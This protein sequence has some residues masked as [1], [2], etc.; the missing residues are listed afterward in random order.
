MEHVAMSRLLGAG[1]QQN[2][3]A[4]REW[5]ERLSELGNPRG[6]FGLGFLSSTG[7]GVNSSQARSL[8]YFTFAA[9]GGDHLAQMAMVSA[10]F[11]FLKL[12]CVSNFLSSFIRATACGLA[13][14]C[15]PIVS[16]RCLTTVA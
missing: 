12:S 1:V 16:Q 15:W 4:A 2:V 5:F 9:L 7:L 14:E 6:Q 13:L 11:L 3:T 8:V 10:P